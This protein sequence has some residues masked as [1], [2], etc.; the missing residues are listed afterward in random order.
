MPLTIDFKD[1]LVLVTGGGRGIGLAI[2]TSLAK[3]GADVA[4]TFTSKNAVAVA[5]E[6]SQR[7]NVKVRAYKCEVTN[8]EEVDRVVIEVERDFGKEIDI[9]VA[10]AGISLWKDAHENSDA[11]FQKVFAVNTFGPFYLA[12]A[13][14]RSWLGLSISTSSES[15]SINA[16]TSTVSKIDEPD[17]KRS[18]LG[19]QILFVS[20]ISGLVA[21]SPQRQAAYNASKGAVSMLAKSLAGE[22]A[23]LGI[24]V[25]SVS[26]GY[27]ST[28]MIAN[29]PDS[30]AKAWVNEWQDRTPVGRFATTNE[31]GDFI[32]TLLSSRMGGGGFMT[33]SDVVVDGG[34]T[35]F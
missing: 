18:N 6:L 17:C 30:S 32:A 34:Y 2:S 3:A 35:I 29:P 1:K 21:M 22:W 11:E 27:V 8:S 26:P 33:G 14:V 16:V 13:L 20:S 12:R 25:N 9:G 10:N 7:C 28:D 31:I 24:S 4:I 15:K 19:K 23:H 5:E